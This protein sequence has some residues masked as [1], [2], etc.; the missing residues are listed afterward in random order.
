MSFIDSIGYVIGRNGL[1]EVLTEVYA[2][3]S[4]LHMLSGKAY[5]RV[6]RGYILVDSTLNNMLVEELIPSVE[7][8]HIAS[9]KKAI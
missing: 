7:P 9:L 1:K 3:N 6:V 4:D 8:E 2:E 5:P